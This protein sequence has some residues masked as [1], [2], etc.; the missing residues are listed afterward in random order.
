MANEKVTRSGEKIYEF[1]FR[2]NQAGRWD[3][4]LQHGKIINYSKLMQTLGLEIPKY[5]KTCTASLNWCEVKYTDQGGYVRDI[6]VFTSQDLW[7][8]LRK[9]GA[10]I[11]RD[12]IAERQ[13]AMEQM[14]T[15]VI[16][17]Y[18]AQGCTFN[19]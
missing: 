7:K 1:R 11:D 15:R 9:S 18:N 17:I 12:L 3:E 13:Q 14:A 19:F 10:L 2:K 5:I 6:R 8:K 4:V 16:N